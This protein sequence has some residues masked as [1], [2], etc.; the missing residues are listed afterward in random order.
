MGIPEPKD[1]AGETL[2]Y[3]IAGPFRNSNMSSAAITSDTLGN[4]TVYQDSSITMVTSQ[5][6]A[7]VFAPGAPLGTQNRDSTTTAACITTGTTITRNLC[8]TNYLETLGGINNATPALNTNPPSFIRGQSS[9]TFNDS[10]LVMT[11][12][13]LMPLVEQRVAREMMAILEQYRIATGIYPWADRSDGVFNFGWNR[14]R[15]P[16]GTAGPTDWGSGG[17]PPLPAWL[18]N[19]CN[20]TLAGQRGWACTIYYSVAQNKLDP[21]CTI[22]SASSLTVTNPSS[23]PADLCLTGVAPVVCTPSVV[24]SGSADLVLITA[25]AATANRTAGW[26]STT[27]NPITLYF[28]DAENGGNNDDNYVVPT[29][30]LNDRDRIYIVR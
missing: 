3:A 26:P 21:G 28:E 24:S 14:N 15:F 5:A 27:F 7:V 17:V 19:G 10:V 1:S 2:W 18:T 29:S 8:A 6:I 20:C 23:R 4:I 16:C 30:T 9:S 22:C 11:N 13:D 12:A 25:G